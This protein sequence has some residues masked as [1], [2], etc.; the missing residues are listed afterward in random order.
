MGRVIKVVLIIIK[1][2]HDL[3]YNLRSW[4]IFSSTSFITSLVVVS[5]VLREYVKTLLMDILLSI[6]LTGHRC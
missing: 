5:F 2:R 4:R 1:M 6:L 3:T